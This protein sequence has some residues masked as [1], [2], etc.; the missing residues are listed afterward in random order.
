MAVPWHA[1]RPSFPCTCACTYSPHM[2]PTQPYAQASR[3]CVSTHTH[4]LTHTRTPTLPRRTERLPLPTAQKN[5][6]A[7]STE[8][9]SE[10]KTEHLLQERT[11]ENLLPSVTKDSKASPH[12]AEGP[13]PGHVSTTLFTAKC[14]SEGIIS[15]LGDFV[16]F[17]GWMEIMIQL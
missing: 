14:I 4:A 13:T 15:W 5:T 8:L 12:P 17:C 10:N 11:R 16:T 2:R 3:P 1:H 6:G 7:Q 9:V